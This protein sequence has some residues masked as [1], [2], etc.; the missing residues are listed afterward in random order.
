MKGIFYRF[1]S[2]WDLLF[3]S[4]VIVSLILTCS[5]VV[6]FLPQLADPQILGKY[7]N[8]LNDGAT[9]ITNTNDSLVTDFNIDIFA[10]SPLFINDF[11]VSLEKASMDA[12]DLYQPESYFIVAKEFIT[13]QNTSITNN[14]AM[15]GFVFAVATD[16]F[17]QLQAYSSGNYSQEGAIIVTDF[18]SD[19]LGNYSAVFRENNITLNVN[20]QLPRNIFES[21]F[22]KLYNYLGVF[23][24]NSFRCFFIEV[25]DF[26]SKFGSYITDDPIFPYYFLHGYVNFEDEQ[27]N[28]IYWSID[29]PHKIDHFEKALTGYLQQQEPSIRITFYFNYYGD[30]ALFVNIVFSFLRGLQILIWSLSLVIGCLTVA[31]IQTTRKNQELKTLFAGQ[32]WFQRLLTHFI[33]TLFIIIVGSGFALLFLYL[34]I[35]LESLFGVYLIFN[36]SVVPKALIIA[37]ILFIGLFLSYLD[38]EFYLKRCINSQAKADTYRPFSTIPLYIK[39]AF[40]ALVLLIIW[41][42]NRNTISLLAFVLFTLAALIVSYLVFLLFKGLIILSGKVFYKKRK[43]ADKPLSP[44]YVLLKLWKTGLTR[45]FFLFTFILTLISSSFL[46]A[47][48]T[49]D[50][51]RTEYL[52]WYGGEI[53]FWAPSTNT[54]QVDEKLALIPEI[55]DYTKMIFFHQ[56]IIQDDYIEFALINNTLTEVNSTFLNERIEWLIGINYSDYFEFYS[57]WKKESWLSKGEI[58][59]PMKNSVFLSKKFLDDGIDIGSTINFVNNSNPLLI[60]GIFTV[61]PTITGQFG[62]ESKEQFIVIQSYDVLQT[63]LTSKKIDYYVRYRV[64]TAEKDIKSTAEELN[65]L[66]TSYNIIEMSYLDQS[67]FV[68]L[69]KIFLEPIVIIAQLFLLLWGSIFLLNNFVRTEE[70]DHGK[71]LGM[72][73]LTKNYRQILT[74][75]KVAETIV[76]YAAF[77]VVFGLLYILTF[78]FLL[79]T[80]LIYAIKTIAVSKYTFFNQL[81]LLLFYPLLLIIQNAAEYLRFRKI[82]LGQIYRFPE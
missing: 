19:P 66:L 57:S 64:H 78:S 14:T 37:G 16:V 59:S 82:N 12:F 67:V 35:N 48:F 68:G 33:E 39:L 41:L 42:Q 5:F 28:V 54:S 65:A 21:T 29:S 44:F 72:I 71:R 23:K 47:N 34:F 77:L 31:K 46:F 30:T 25:T 63:Y 18:D 58:N 8:K 73:A 13:I 4:I 38:F 7:L 76:F 24:R 32:N 79:G 17:T 15:G 70:S 55:V 51:K 49:A 69:R 52:W 56:Y 61:W 10:E 9:F 40:P 45:K 2:R 81:F 60:Q 53:V 75:F 1:R 80:G 43:R 20:Q 26:V 62:T 27:K 22:S 11:P 3:K 50:A 74:R 36:L 6:L